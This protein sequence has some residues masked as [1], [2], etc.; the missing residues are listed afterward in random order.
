MNFDIS[1]FIFVNIR[2][3]NLICLK[4]CTEVIRHRIAF[5]KCILV[6]ETG[7]GLR[8]GRVLQISQL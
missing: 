1:L 8:N 5:S 2:S 6:H 3:D 4:T 7:G